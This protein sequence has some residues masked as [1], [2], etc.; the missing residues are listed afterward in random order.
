MARVVASTLVCYYE[1]YLGTMMV[2]RMLPLCSP[3]R[4]IS[5]PRFRLLD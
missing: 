2:P 4:Y 1:L 5:N 3:T